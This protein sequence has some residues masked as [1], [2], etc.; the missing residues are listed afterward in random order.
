MSAL[1]LVGLDGKSDAVVEQ[2]REPSAVLAHLYC[3][4]SAGL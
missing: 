3:Q 1:D 4:L 2:C